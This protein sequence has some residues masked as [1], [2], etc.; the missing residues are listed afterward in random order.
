MEEINLKDLFNYFTNKLIIIG[1]SFL[2]IL[3][4]GTIYSG[5]IKT[6]LYKSNANV[7]LVSENTNYSQ[8]ELAFN[9]KIVS[10]YTK[11]ITSRKVLS[12]VIEKLNLNYT[13]EELVK[14]I[15]VT[16]ETNT[17]LIKINVESKNAKEAYR[18]ANTI[19]PIFSEE[20]TNIYNISNVSLLDEA[21]ISNKP[22]NMNLIKDMAIYSVVGLVLGS[23]I[24]FMMFY[25]DTTVKSKEEIEKKFNI[26]VIGSVPMIK[27]K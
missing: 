20:V 19:V 26:S 3:L 27:I 12:Q 16:S 22:Y 11:I 13:Y 18:I 24:V 9:Q 8:T 17:E 15:N 25:F 5:F 7:I 23:G 6:P 10:T 1:I 2:S 21:I 14:M 4:L